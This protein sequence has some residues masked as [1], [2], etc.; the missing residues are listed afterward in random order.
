[1]IR[2]L[3]KIFINNHKDYKDEGVRRHYGILCGLVG[4]LFNL[5]LFAGKITAGIIGKS[6]SIIADAFNN[7]SD[8]GSSLITLIGFKLAGQKPDPEHPFGH[9]R[10][11]Y[12]SGLFV[13]IIIMIMSFELIKSSVEKIINPETPEFSA[14]TVIVL[15]ISILIKLYMSFYNFSYGKKLSST[16]LKATAIDSMSDSIATSVVL[17]TTV[18]AYFFKLNLDG[19]AG[20]AVGLFIGYAGICTMK[21]TISPLLGQMPDPEFVEEVEKLVMEDEKVLGI[22]DMVVHDYGPGRLMVSLHAEV[23]CDEDILVI[24]D[25]IDNIENEL[26]EKL[27][28]EATIHMDPV[29]INDPLCME[30]KENVKNFINELGESLSIHDFRMVPGESHT[31]LIFDVVVP[32][33]FKKDDNRLIREIKSGIY[34]RYPG[35]N[36]V[37]K[38]DRMYASKPKEN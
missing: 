6:I 4:I 35:H 13:S 5:F 18:I 29:N 23:S 14:F 26:M 8:A 11:E 30:M 31:N 37:I 16:S 3:S 9:G 2:L 32:Y 27:N 20:V 36:C 15:I 21:D 22:H 19:Y 1:M 12:I 25:H 10:I 17:I 38:I 34:D 7:L 33:D 28:C 24:H